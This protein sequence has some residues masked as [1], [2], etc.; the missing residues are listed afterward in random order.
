MK[1]LLKKEVLESSLFKYLISG[2]TA[3]IIHYAILIGLVEIYRVNP[4]LATFIG[5]T[6]A[7]VVNYPL[8][9]Y[10]TFTAL[11]P[12]SVAF[13]KYVL[14]TS[15]AYGVNLLTFWILEE[16]IGI[17]Y[18]IAQMIAT[19]VAL[20]INFVVNSRYTFAHPTQKTAEQT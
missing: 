20:V 6:V 16:A 17:N 3:A 8:Q 9:Y 7:T 18:I 1:R 2:G 5:L 10:W 19:G 15:I 12:H 4:F 14:V 11:T 13:P